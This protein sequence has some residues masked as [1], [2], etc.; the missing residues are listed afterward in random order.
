MKGPGICHGAAGSGYA[1]LLFY[2][3]TKEQVRLFFLHSEIRITC[4]Q[5]NGSN[6]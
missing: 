4:M 5:E 3:L 1:F 6:N 2:R